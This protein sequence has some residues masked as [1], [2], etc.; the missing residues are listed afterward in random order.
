MFMCK[1]FSSFTF[2]SPTRMYDT[3]RSP[4]EARTGPKVFISFLLLFILFFI[5]LLKLLYVFILVFIHP[6]HP[7]HSTNCVRPNMKFSLITAFALIPTIF[8]EV[9]KLDD[10]NFKE[11]TKDKIVFIKFYAPWCGHCKESK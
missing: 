10:S 4:S 11:L 6:F 3:A 7:F 2:L 1:H 8:G 5:G 9:V